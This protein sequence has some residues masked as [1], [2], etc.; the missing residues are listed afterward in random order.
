RAASSLSSRR[1][2]VHAM[3]RMRHPDPDSMPGGR[4]PGNPAPTSP[5]R[6]DIH[7]RQTGRAPDA[8][9]P[10]KRPEMGASAAILAAVARGTPKPA[11]ETAQKAPV[12]RIGA[13][14]KAR[15]MNATGEPIP[16]RGRHRA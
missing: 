14:K 12:P 5:L 8:K 2:S 9:E 16:H 7:E 6:A 15:A 3:V 1:H 13:R 10:G 11:M 4:M